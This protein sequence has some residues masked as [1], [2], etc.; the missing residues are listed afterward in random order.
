MPIVP[1]PPKYTVIVNTVQAR[2]EQGAY[3]TGGMLPSEAQLVREFG[4]SRSTVVRA[5]EYLRQQGWLQG[6]QGRGRI[7]LGRPALVR[8]PAPAPERVRRILGTGEAT[9]VVLLRVGPAKVPERIA[10]VLALPPRSRVLARRRLVVPAEGEP[11]SLEV[12]Y[13]QPELAQR[14]GLDLP[15]P[16]HDG[17]VARLDRRGIAP[18]DVMEWLS[19]RLPTPQETALLNVERRRCLTT[20]LLVVRDRSAQPLV[21]VDSAVPADRATLEALFSLD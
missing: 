21:A 12:V 3:P 11:V 8:P 17:L 5:L 18:H 7:V 1:Q 19:S 16:V 15:S 4:A 10:A 9:G 2:I 13:A 14:A 20:T 6:A